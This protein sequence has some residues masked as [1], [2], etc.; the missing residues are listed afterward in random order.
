MIKVNSPLVKWEVGVATEV[1][2]EKIWSAC[3]HC[4]SE[5]T[6]WSNPYNAVFDA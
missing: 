2:R 5:A 3:L 6:Y 4:L 1:G